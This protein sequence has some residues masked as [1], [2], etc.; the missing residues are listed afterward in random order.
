VEADDDFFVGYLSVE[1]DACAVVLG[2]AVKY[3]V[4][5]LYESVD[6]LPIED[7]GDPDRLQWLMYRSWSSFNEMERCVEMPLPW[8]CAA[9]C[10]CCATNV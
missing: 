1:H 2:S 4:K 6:F 3:S 9:V 10:V 5:S 8:Q 7:I